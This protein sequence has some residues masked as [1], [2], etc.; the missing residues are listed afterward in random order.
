MEKIY[1]AAGWFSEK[2]AAHRDIVR[3]VLKELKLPHYSP[4]HDGKKLS[5]NNSLDV[6]NEN[7]EMISKAP[8]LIASTCE[9]DM[10][11]LFECGYA[12]SL[13]VPIVYVWLGAL[14][15]QRFNLMLAKTAS[16][17]VETKTA[18]YK[19]LEQFS[20]TGVAHSVPYGGDIE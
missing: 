13:N 18:L 19:Y 16:A 7:I 6:Y 12:A 11:T 4:Q 3:S 5:I 1:L 15:G 10:G 17:V 9:K 20:R 2:Q 14:P 8:L